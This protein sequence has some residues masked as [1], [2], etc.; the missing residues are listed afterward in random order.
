MKTIY[1]D[2]NATTAVAP[3]V[4][5]AMLPYLTERFWN[6]SAPYARA[7]EVRAATCRREGLV[8]EVLGAATGVEVVAQAAVDG[9][10]AR[11][12]RR[13]ERLRAAGGRQQLRNAVRLQERGSSR[14]LFLPARTVW[15]HGFAPCEVYRDKT[16][17]PRTPL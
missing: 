1:L 4:R 7:R 16:A 13:V 3:E 17:G 14:H 11:G 2:N 10:G 12:E 6:P 5:E 9:V 15:V 8:V